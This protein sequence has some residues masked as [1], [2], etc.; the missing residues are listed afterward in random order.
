MLSFIDNFWQLFVLSAPWLLVGLVVAAIMKVWIPMSWLQQQLGGNGIKPVIKGALLGA[1]LPLCS[2]GVIPAAMQLR[3]GGAGKGATVAF[4]SATPETGVDSISVSYVLLGP[5]MAI[6]RPV[7][8]II[9]AIVSGL[10]VGKASEPATPVTEPA[11]AP[12]LPT[13]KSCC[14][15]KAAAVTSEPV[16]ASCCATNQTKAA[17]LT[18]WQQAKQ[19]LEYSS[20]KLLSDFYLWLLLGLFFAAL[21]QTLVPMD[22][23]TQYGS[24]I[25]TM[26]LM[27]LISVPMYVCATA[28][29]PIAAAMMLVG[30]SPGAALVFMQAGPATNIATISV[31]YK[32]LGSRALAAYLFGVIVMSVLFGWLLDQGLAYFDISVQGAMQHQH[33]VLPGWLELAAALLLAGLIL[34]IIWRQLNQRRLRHQLQS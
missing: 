28:S 29:T 21:V 10:L 33:S 20:G 8:A 19:G 18:L 1:P 7:A 4:L 12:A 27:V 23:L 32:E 9:S 26:L 16:K 6:V 24:S 11:P 14:A 3:R 34:R 17:K 15:G 22:Y 13:A 31:V 25:W 5:V 2:C 30:I